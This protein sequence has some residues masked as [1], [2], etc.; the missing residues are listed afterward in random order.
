MLSVSEDVAVKARLF[1]VQFPYEGMETNEQIATIN[2]QK[3][4]SVGGKVCQLRDLN[5]RATV[6][7]EHQGL[8]LKRILR[9]LRSRRGYLLF[10]SHMKVWKQMSR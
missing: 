3:V 5:K 4:L 7:Q 1:I 8:N 10:N 9:R 6:T 2:I